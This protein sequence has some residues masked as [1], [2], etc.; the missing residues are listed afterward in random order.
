MR[1]T[2]LTRRSCSYSSLMSGGGEGIVSCAWCASS[3]N[4]L[5]SRSGR[6]VSEIGCFTRDALGGRTAEMGSES[7]GLR[8]VC[9]PLACAWSFMVGP[10]WV[11][12]V[13][14][15][16]LPRAKYPTPGRVSNDSQ[17]SRL[18]R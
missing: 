10:S 3:G 5:L 15:H 7:A 12:A 1:D 4:R 14:P 11:L 13:S 2:A 18:S 9:G 17:G 16:R 6:S 8:S